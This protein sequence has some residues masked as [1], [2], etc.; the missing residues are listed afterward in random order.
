M[1]T[2]YRTMNEEQLKAILSELREK[3]NGFLKLNLSLDMSRGKPNKHQLDL[4][5]KMLGA[6]S[7]PDDCFSENGIDCRNYGLLDGIPEAKRI[8]ADLLA[9]PSS[10]L[11]V[12]GNSSLNI[13]YDTLIRCML[14]GSSPSTE[15]WV[16]QGRIKFLC[17]SPGYDRH[18]SM[19]ESLGIEMITVRMTSTGPDM[20]IVEKLVSED[21]SIKG[22]WCVP[23]YS[24]PDGI[25]YSDE[26]VRRFARLKPAA[27]DFRIFWDDAYIVHDL[28][29]DKSDRLLS[30]FRETH[31]AGNPNIAYTF[32][33][34]SKISF[35]GSGVSVF[36]ASDANIAYT[37]S[38]MTVQTI[39]CDKL[40]MLRHVRFFESAEGIK[41]HM[42]LH[43]DIIRPKFEAILEE[44]ERELEPCGIARWTKPLGGYFISL[45]V[46]E[47][48]AKRVHSLMMDA[49]VKMT[50]AGATYPYGIDPH[51]SNLRIAP[52]Y[53]PLEE[54]VVAA[55]VLATCVKIASIEKLLAEYDG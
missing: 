3:Y 39:G 31:I 18:F 12:C 52:T 33:S 34:T 55:K 23:K 53:P 15:P 13:M 7:T 37:K 41:R 45:Y 40:N 42:M 49:G 6:I 1:S 21:E 5:Q 4:T 25:T 2:Q 35:P 10:N 9:I 47:G 27:K 28:Y 16:K 20:N 48:C 22:I 46:P 51:D 38:L 30:L 32:C 50:E 24:N 44:F 26:T 11:I 8:F 54:I 17:P 14:Y 19:C 43:A 36:A 29:P